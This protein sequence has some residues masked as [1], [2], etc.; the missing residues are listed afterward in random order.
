MNF[1]FMSK[2]GLVEA[3]QV[4]EI[5][6]A[7]G[8]LANP[9]ELPSWTVEMLALRRIELRYNPRRADVRI[10]AH[11]IVSVAWEDWIVRLQ[12]RR[13]MLCS[14]MRADCSECKGG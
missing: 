5:F 14:S 3:V 11:G 7:G 12:D 10:E 4:R 13:V 8:R 9:P 6:R 2:S 1:K